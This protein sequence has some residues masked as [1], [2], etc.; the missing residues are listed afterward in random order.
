M[1]PRPV[2]SLAPSTPITDPSNRLASSWGLGRDL[3]RLSSNG[4][5]SL[6]LISSYVAYVTA[7]TST[8]RFIMSTHVERA[9]KTERP[10][11]PLDALVYSGTKLTK[12]GR[13]KTKLLNSVRCGKV[14]IRIVCYK[15]YFNNLQALC[16][17]GSIISVVR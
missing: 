2:Q 12:Q 13:P 10:R 5:H 4:N 17:I 14:T 3:R 9:W 16:H 11:L 8:S 15:I 1:N 6:R 7:C